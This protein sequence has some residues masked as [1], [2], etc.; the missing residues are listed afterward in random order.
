MKR[1]LILIILLLA[2]PN[3]VYSKSNRIIPIDII[4]SSYLEQNSFIVK[5]NYH[6]YYIIDDNKNT[7]WVEGVAGDG[8]GEKIVLN[9]L[10]QI[11]VDS[12]H[13]FFRNGY[14]KSEELYQ[15]NNRL[16]DI[17]IKFINE[18][19]SYAES[20]FSF[21]LEDC[22]GYQKITIDQPITFSTIEIIIASVYRGSLYQ[23]T[24]LSDLYIEGNFKEDLLK[25][26]E[27]IKSEY[28]KWFIKRNK[29][30][31]FFNNLPNDYPFNRY[32]KILYE[33]RFNISVEH[34]WT[35]F[36]SMFKD[37]D[38]LRQFSE[39]N[40]TELD[41]ILSTKIKSENDVV[42]ENFESD[43]FQPTILDDLNINLA[44]YLWLNK[45]KFCKIDKHS[46]DLH[47]Y[48]IASLGN[49]GK[50]LTT[51]SNNGEISRIDYYYY[52]NYGKLFYVDVDKNYED[53]EFFNGIY[54]I[55]KQNKIFKIIH[56]YAIED[57]PEKILYLSIYK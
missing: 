21:T 49:Y 20:I 42:M 41:S 19:S 40:F 52:D 31:Y 7:A 27:N 12:L 10:E 13:L 29:K 39:I 26:Q 56:L 57:F 2:I 48:K 28:E 9:F 18:I 45:L 25:K 38:L 23:D 15:K 14:Q 5:A 33:K 47:S 24:C 51:I 1:L 46:N 17:K 32:S 4:S 6:P 36:I 30:A 8:V 54:L 35:A 16:K 34:N 44:D 43:I 11:K 50:R 37:D 22:L 55:W 53:G 3:F